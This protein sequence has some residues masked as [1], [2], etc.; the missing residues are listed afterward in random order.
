MTTPAMFYPGFTS[1]AG[2]FVLSLDLLGPETCF[3]S[4]TTLTAA[5]NLSGWCGHALGN[6]VAG[7]HGHVFNFVL[8]G[9]TMT[10]TDGVVGTL[11]VVPDVT[12]TPAQSCITG[13]T[14]FLVSG[15]LELIA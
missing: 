3:W 13:A 12:S 10:F 14:R 1:A 8:E 5:G 9:T 11:Q 15:S 2:S 7:I 4:M 6:G